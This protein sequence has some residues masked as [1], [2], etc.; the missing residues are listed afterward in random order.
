M[1]T[2]SEP[3]MKHIILKISSEC[4]QSP[5]FSGSAGVASV[6]HAIVSKYP[7]L[8]MCCYVELQSTLLVCLAAASGSSTV[9]KNSLAIL[10]GRGNQ[11]R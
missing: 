10:K 9:L 6:L 7:K 1:K 11:H 4:T 5:S 8:S 2:L 3:I